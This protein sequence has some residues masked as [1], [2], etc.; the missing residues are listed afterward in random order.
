MLWLLRQL[1]PRFVVLFAVLAAMFGGGGVAAAAPPAPTGL[2]PANGA[3]VTV[4]FTISW[5]A[6]SDPSGITAYN[7]QVSNS[8]TMSPVILLNS[9]NGTTTQD[10][11]SGL[12]NGTYYWHV[13]AISGA[14]LQ[15]AW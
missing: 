4:P 14:F 3:S 10:T 12:A 1:A 13:Q 11:V 2:S 7:W 5:N 6:V 15:S 9:T 8:P